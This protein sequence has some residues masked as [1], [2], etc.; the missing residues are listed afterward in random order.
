MDPPSLRYGA[1]GTIDWKVK[2]EGTGV[3]FQI[4]RIS[5]FQFLVL[6]FNH[7]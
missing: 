2:T 5:A 4:F 1:A 7:E 6:I 3:L